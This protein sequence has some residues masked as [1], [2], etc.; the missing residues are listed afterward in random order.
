[1]TNRTTHKLIAQHRI[2]RKFEMKPAALPAINENEAVVYA[3][4]LSTNC[5]QGPNASASKALLKASHKRRRRKAKLQV[6]FSISEL[7]DHSGLMCDA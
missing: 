2:A 6:N 1:M 5:W 3:I 7:T 4:N